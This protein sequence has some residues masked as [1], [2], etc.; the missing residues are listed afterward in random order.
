MAINSKQKGNRGE[1]EWAKVCKEQGYECRRSQQYAG[2][3]KESADVIGLPYI[4]QEV[5]YGYD[6]TIEEIR[7]FLIQAMTDANNSLLTPI[8]AHKKT[9]G[10]W[11]VTME[12]SD[13]VNMCLLA[14]DAN[15]LPINSITYEITYVTMPADDWFKIYKEFESSMKIKAG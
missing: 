3:T 13:F 9:Y 10:K 4:H 5:K 12:H 14:E 1:R 11:F 15:A 6:M 2:G 7:K 8:V